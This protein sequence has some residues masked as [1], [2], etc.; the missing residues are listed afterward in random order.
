MMVKVFEKVRGEQNKHLKLFYLIVPVL[1]INF[2][3]N[4]LIV[5][6]RLSKKN[7]V[8]CYITVKFIHYFLG[9]WICVRNLIFFK[10]VRYKN[11][12]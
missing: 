2:V 9:G 7:S 11:R 1:T 5:K 12:V 4:M 8:D 10:F 3:E 6:E